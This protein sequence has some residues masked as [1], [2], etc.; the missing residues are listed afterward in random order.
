MLNN[1]A[2]I[3]ARLSVRKVPNMMRPTAVATQNM[4]QMQQRSYYKDNVLMTRVNG[5]Y[6][7]DP[8]AVAERVVRLV[9][10]HDNCIDPE[11]ITLNSTWEELGLNGLDLAELQIAA[12]REFDFEIDEEVCESMKTVNDLV[13]CIARDF[14]SK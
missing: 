3:S 9:A 4:I 14:Y 5:D 6:F 2:R 7:Q 10:L 13:E 8:V 11:A 1:F 12:E